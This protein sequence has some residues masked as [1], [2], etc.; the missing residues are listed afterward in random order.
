MTV[1]RLEWEGVPLNLA[2]YAAKDERWQAP[3]KIDRFFSRL[4]DV[5]WVIDRNND[6]RGDSSAF[7]SSMAF[8][9]ANKVG[10]APSSGVASDSRST[11]ANVE[12]SLSIR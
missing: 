8:F 10:P 6:N 4:D 1:L 3:R 5:G 2:I 12:A 9:D 7:S 11:V